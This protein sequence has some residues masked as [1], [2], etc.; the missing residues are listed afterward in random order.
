MF[1]KI[2]KVFQPHP[3]LKELVNNIM[4]QKVTLDP[5]DPKPVFLMPPIQEQGLFFYP[6]DPVNIELISSG[7]RI[8]LPKSIVIARRT[9]LVNTVMGH[10]HLVLKVGFQPGG[11]FRL[12]GIPMKD[13]EP[14]DKIYETVHFI[15]K[16]V[17]FIVEQLNRADS[18]ECMVD[19]IQKWLLGKLLHLKELLPIDRALP[20]MLKKGTLNN[21][22]EV[23]SQSCV[24]IRQLERLFQQRIGLS[25]QYYSRLVRFTKAWI[26][27]ENNP[28]VNWT[29]LAYECGYFD[30]THL[31][32]D[33]KEFIGYTPSYIEKNLNSLPFSLQHEVFL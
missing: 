30:Q 5:N 23:A 26:I 10:N 18:L 9:R 22:S 4:I 25:P 16:D 27:K 24:S 32:R 12:L 19:I 31:I 7:E 28:I 33:F 2:H 14:D 13:F 8:E 17:N 3:Q 15:D 1:L 11:L 6:Q 29:N 21:I 20:D